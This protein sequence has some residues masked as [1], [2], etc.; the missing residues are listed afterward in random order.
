[1]S[2]RWC[3]L[4]HH[5]WISWHRHSHITNRIKV[6]IYFNLIFVGTVW[7]IGSWRKRRPF[8]HFVFDYP[9]LNVHLWLDGIYGTVILEPCLLWHNIIVCCTLSGHY[10]A[11]LG[12]EIKIAQPSLIT[13]PPRQ[14]LL[15]ASRM[16]SLVLRMMMTMLEMESPVHDA[17]P[18][19]IMTPPPPGHSYKDNWANRARPWQDQWSNLLN[20]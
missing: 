19:L 4:Y 2:P 15:D 20:C 11:S 1:M 13:R 17:L 12:F 7:F 5:V 9:F 3:C 6:I 18:P 16:M 14:L 10:T 8:Q